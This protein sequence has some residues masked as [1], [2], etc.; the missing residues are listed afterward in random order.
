MA[1]RSTT[2]T[3]RVYE[4]VEDEAVVEAV[5]DDAPVV[6]ETKVAPDEHIYVVS[7]DT[8]GSIAEREGL[9]ARTLAEAN[10][11]TIHSLLYVGTR[12]KRP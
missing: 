4:P 12:L 5:T 6:V 7:S 2:R 8:W 11:L 3:K 1:E 10:G 9:D